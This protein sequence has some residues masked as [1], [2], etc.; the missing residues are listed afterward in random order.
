MKHINFCPK[1]GSKVSSITFL[2]KSNSDYSD[3]MD[4]DTELFQCVNN[5][6]SEMIPENCDFLF[7][8]LR[9]PKDA[10]KSINNFNEN[11][12]LQEFDPHNLVSEI[13]WFKAHHDK[14]IKKFKE[15]FGEENVTVGYGIASYWC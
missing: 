7:E 1:C 4:T 3:C 15:Y 9:R 13:K 12:G 8:N 2:R 5:D 11:G 10:P 6:V 14:W